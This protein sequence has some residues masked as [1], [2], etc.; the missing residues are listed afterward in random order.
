VEVS[1]VG[2]VLDVSRLGGARLGGGDDS[3]ASLEEMKTRGRG[4]MHDAL[5]ACTASG[6]A[7]VL[8]AKD[9]D[10][11]RKVSS[12][13]VRCELWSFEDLLEFARKREG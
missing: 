3:G 13:A 6:E 7:D 11:R 8:V 4:K 10:L 1:T 5:I 2:F 9:Q 12:S